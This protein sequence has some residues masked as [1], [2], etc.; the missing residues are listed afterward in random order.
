MFSRRL[1]D[2]LHIVYMLFAD[3]LHSLGV[4]FGGKIENML[5]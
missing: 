4:P 1:L 2:S 3:P 5:W